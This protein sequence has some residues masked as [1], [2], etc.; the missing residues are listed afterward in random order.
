MSSAQMKVYVPLV[1]AFAARVLTF[2]SVVAEKLGLH[3]TDLRT[4]RLLSKQS[5]SAGELTE[6][7]GLTGAAVTALIDRLE[8]AGYVLRERDTDDRRRVTV[9]ALPEKLR[10]VNRLY[11]GQGARMSKLLDKYSAK[12]FAVIADYLKQT[13]QVLAEEAKKL[14]AH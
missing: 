13:T 2:H 5:M 4:L 6:E 8:S 12:E 9:R 7:T 10:E 3:A 14:Q 11:E 1:Q